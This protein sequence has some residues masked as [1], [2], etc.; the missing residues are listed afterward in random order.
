MLKRK[1]DALKAKFRKIMVA[2]LEAK[3]NM[4]EECGQALFLFAEAK[5]AAGDFE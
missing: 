2:L 4:G 1:A 3:K 5:Y